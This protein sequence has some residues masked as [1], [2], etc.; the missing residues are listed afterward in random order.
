M[1]LRV[2]VAA[3]FQGRGQDRIRESEFV[4]ASSLDRDWFSPEQAARVVDLGVERGLLSRDG[5]ELVVEFDPDTVEV[6]RDFTPSEDLL[7][8]RSPFEQILDAL[9]AEVGMEKRDAVA[10]INKLQAD[11]GLTIDAAAVVYGARKAVDVSDAAATARA[12]L[13]DD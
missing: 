11:L 5:D 1:S 10:G 9:T 12:R 4:V 2:V 7:T 3:P 6:P 8:T 13:T